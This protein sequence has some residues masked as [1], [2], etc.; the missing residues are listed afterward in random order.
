MTRGVA[1]RA[2][3]FPPPGT[4]PTVYATV[5]PFVPPNELRAR[6]GSVVTVQDVRWLRC[7]LKTI[8]LLPNVLAKQGAAES[9]G[10]E[11][12]LVRDGV[13]TEGSHAN[14]IGVIDGVLRTHPLNN[15]I[16]PGITRA[17][18]LDLARQLGIPVSEVAFTKAD[19]PRL[20]EL[21]LA[22]TTTD[23]MPIIK[24]DDQTI[25]SGSPGP[26][27]LRL[28]AALRAHMEAYCASPP[29]L[30]STHATA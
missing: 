11:A 15:L 22:G 23:V 21:F 27:S 24:V 2:H 8:Q 9:G 4:Q 3:A 6:G 7:N 12:L 13:V 20:D 29:Y 26:I 1:P 5:N 19:I 17:V 25:G 16:L 28:Y 10:V 14:C 18:V 30:T